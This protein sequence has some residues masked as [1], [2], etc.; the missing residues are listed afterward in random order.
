MFKLMTINNLSAK[1]KI[2]TDNPDENQA[3]ELLETELQPE[4]FDEEFSLNPENA[5]QDLPESVIKPQEFTVETVQD[6]VVDTRPDSPVPIDPS[7]QDFDPDFTGFLQHESETITDPDH[8]LDLCPQ[9]PTPL[10]AARVKKSSPLS[11]LFKEVTGEDTRL[12]EHGNLKPK[13]KD[14]VNTKNFTQKPEHAL[15]PSHEPKLMTLVKGSDGTPMLPIRFKVIN[16]PVHG[17]ES[18]RGREII[19]K[20]C[21]YY[22]GGD[23]TMALLQ[24]KV[25]REITGRVKGTKDILSLIDLY[26]ILAY[27][28][29]HGYYEPRA[30]KNVELKAVRRRSQNELTIKEFTAIVKYWRVQGAVGPRPTALQC[31]ENWEELGLRV[32]VFIEPI[33]KILKALANRHSS[34]YYSKKVTPEIQR[35]DRQ[36]LDTL[37]QF[38]S[39]IEDII[40]NAK[41]AINPR[42]GNPILVIE[43]N[44]IINDVIKNQFL[45]KHFPQLMDVF[46]IAGIGGQ[47]PAENLESLAESETDN[48][49]DDQLQEVTEIREM[50]ASVESVDQVLASPE[51]Q[52]VTDAQFQQMSAEEQQEFLQQLKQEQKETDRKIIQDG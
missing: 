4:E 10:A 6:L 2:M 47:Q 29:A 11:R 39:I 26:A 21:M 17:P 22:R 36:K 41:R 34:D 8:G 50:L 5:V 42:T 40:T 7:G 31:K 12:D 18:F 23:M 30:G 27:A 16:D 37:L 13:V 14:T 46:D 45:Y 25:N 1:E 20:V 3:E 15:E 24:N 38:S 51:F 9:P 32:D 49:F 19:R 52:Q 33:A 43:C 44:E 28:Q 48:N 35:L